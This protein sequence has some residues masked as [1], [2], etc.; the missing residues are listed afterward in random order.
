MGVVSDSTFH[1]NWILRSD[2]TDFFGLLDFVGSQSIEIYVDSVWALTIDIFYS[3]QLVGYDAA[4]DEIM[5][6][7]SRR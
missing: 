3:D 2:T 6:R 1:G 4:E 5:Y 7:F